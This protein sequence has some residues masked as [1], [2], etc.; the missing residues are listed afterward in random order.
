MLQ[1]AR[2]LGFLGPGP[3][4]AHVAHAAG[5]AAAIEAGGGDQPQR[6]ADLGSGGGVP[7]LPLALRF[8]ECR[9]V[10]VESGV[11]RAAFLR[12]AVRALGLEA[13]VA[14]VEGRAEVVGRAGE[15]RGTFDL[16]VARG[17]GPPPVVAECAAPLLRIGGRA[18]V[19]E[20]P[21]GDPGRWPPGPLALLGLRG[22][23]S[24]TAAG[25]AYQILVQVAPCPSQFPRRVGM[26]A[27]RPLF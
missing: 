1:E 2:Q 26:P 25:A 3:V 8:H 22:R 10:L 13:R 7:G 27:K 6:A 11:R 5:F 17:F 18:V 21:G 4:A 23:P 9:W 24:V 20:P 15:W 16:V 14:V 12:D 19:S